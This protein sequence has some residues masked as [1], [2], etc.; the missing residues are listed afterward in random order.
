MVVKLS[1]CELWVV[2]NLKCRIFDISSNC[3]PY[4]ARRRMILPPFD[5]SR[6]DDSNG[7]K[8]IF[9]R[10]LGGSQFDETLNGAVNVNKFI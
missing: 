1:F 10:A 2:R 6:R 4:R 9:L 7:G 8:I 3:K 5:S